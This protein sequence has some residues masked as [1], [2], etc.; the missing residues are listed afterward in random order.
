MVNENVNIQVFQNSALYDMAAFSVCGGATQK[1]LQYLAQAHI[2]SK[3]IQ[4]CV[5]SRHFKT[6]GN[7]QRTVSYMSTPMIGVMAVSLILLNLFYV[8]LSET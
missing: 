5:C 2:L 3:T 8:F 1:Y 7:F 6:A 4:P